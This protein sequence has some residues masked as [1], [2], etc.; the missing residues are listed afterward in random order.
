MIR[1][2]GV[3]NFDTAQLEQAAAVAGADR[4]ACNQVLYHLAERA[5]E[6]DVLPWCETRGIALSTPGAPR[7]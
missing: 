6:H 4:I 5:I 1:A 3:S 7:P 2:W